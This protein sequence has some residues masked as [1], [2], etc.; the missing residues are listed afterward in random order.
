MP[1][2]LEEPRGTSTPVLHN[3]SIGEEYIGGLLKFEQRQQT[4]ADKNPKFKDDGK[5]MWELVVHMLT[6]RSTMEAGIG[7]NDAIPERGQIVRAILRGK[8]FGRWI[9]EKG[10]LGRGI[11]VGDKIRLTTDL[12]VS[13]RGKTAVGEF[14]TNEQ[15]AELKKSRDWEDRKVTLGMYGPVEIKPASDA[16][17]AFV[18]ECE[19]A[20]HQLVKEG[21][22][23]DD[24]PFD[25][26][27]RDSTGKIEGPVSGESDPW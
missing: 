2:T 13:Y 18:V 5:P 27:P 26:M 12:G 3:R 6:L 21:I 24:D 17:A 15:I 25:R 4:D 11:Q 19:Q 9:D 1:I 8:T 23:L 16:D 22:R 10:S 14:T 20:Y 7:G